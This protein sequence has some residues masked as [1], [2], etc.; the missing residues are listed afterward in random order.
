[1]WGIQPFEVYARFVG[2]RKLIEKRYVVVY[3][4]PPWTKTKDEPLTQAHGPVELVDAD[5]DRGQGLL[6]RREKDLQEAKAANLEGD[7]EWYLD[8]DTSG[9]SGS[10]SWR[11]ND[12]SRTN[13]RPK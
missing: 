11:R 10:K 8:Q 2:L 12:E 5:S 4:K 1:M 7:C 9:S 6:A 13:D 3:N